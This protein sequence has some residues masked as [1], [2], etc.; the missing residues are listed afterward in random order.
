MGKPAGTAFEAFRKRFEEIQAG[1]EKRQYL[2]P[3]FMSGHPGCTIDDMVE[4]AEYI[5]DTHLYTEQVQDFTPTP[6]TTSTCMFHTGI[7]PLTMEQVHV[8]KDHEKEI[9]RAMLHYRDPANR[10]LIE[11]GLRLAGRTDLVGNSGKCLVRP[12]KKRKK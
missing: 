6:M 12:E 3:Y 5:R 1:K 10:T 8:P 2:V 9:Q 11:E 7:N 4:L